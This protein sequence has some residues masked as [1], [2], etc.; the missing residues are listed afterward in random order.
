MAGR[1]PITVTTKYD[2][3]YYHAALKAIKAMVKFFGYEG[4][5]LYLS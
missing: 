5:K 2:V 3:S 1:R 4:G